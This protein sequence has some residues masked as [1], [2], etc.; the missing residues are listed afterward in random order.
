MQ[1]THIESNNTQLMFF[2]I[3]KWKRCLWFM[4]KWVSSMCPRRNSTKCNHTK[5]SCFFHQ[6]TI[7]TDFNMAD[8]ELELSTYCVVFSL[9]PLFFC[10]VCYAKLSQSFFSC[11]QF[12]HP[13]ILIL[14]FTTIWWMFFFDL[15]NYWVSLRWHF[16]A[17]VRRHYSNLACSH[18]CLVP[19]QPQL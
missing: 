4:I 10:F 1:S 11:A 6:R 9:S 19:Y 12:H 17:I 15:T 7:V 16:T 3:N 2:K 13:I 5:L 18:V 14:W 8:N